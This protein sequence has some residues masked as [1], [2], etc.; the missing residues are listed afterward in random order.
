M[1]G[2]SLEIPSGVSLGI[3]VDGCRSSDFLGSCFGRPIFRWKY[4]SLVPSDSV[5]AWV[6]RSAR[7][8]V[9]GRNKPAVGS[10]EVNV[11]MSA[12]RVTSS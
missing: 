3:A 6:G 1:A 2:K 8:N 11:G 9:S 5:G 12:A 10:I 4:F 7:C